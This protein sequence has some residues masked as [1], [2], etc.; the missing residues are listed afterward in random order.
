MLPV[1]TALRIAGVSSTS[2]SF[3][4]LS[5]SGQESLARELWDEQRKGANNTCFLD[6]VVRCTS[7]DD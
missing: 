1:G 3:G 5:D 4:P 6:G 7:I 2:N